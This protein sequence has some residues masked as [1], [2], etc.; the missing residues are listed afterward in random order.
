MNK[1]RDRVINCVIHRVIHCLKTRDKR[2][3]FFSGRVIN[4]SGCVIKFR[5]R[6]INNLEGKVIQKTAPN[7]ITHDI[8]VITHLPGL[9]EPTVFSLGPTLTFARKAARQIVWKTEKKNIGESI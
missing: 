1:F 8:F 6:V 4:F 7:F 3:I 5:R 2:V 9:H